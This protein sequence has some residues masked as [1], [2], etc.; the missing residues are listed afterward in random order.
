MCMPAARAFWARRATE[1]ST[2]FPCCIIR[3]ANSSTTMT[4]NGSFS[5]I[6]TSVPSFAIGTS[7]SVPSG[8]I[9]ATVASFFGRGG[10]ASPL[11]T[12]STQPL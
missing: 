2:S 11:S 5:G 12:R 4:M 8:A 10:L 6:S 3:S 9:A 1:T 7:T